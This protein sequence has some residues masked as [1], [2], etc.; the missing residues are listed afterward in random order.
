MDP[1]SVTAGVMGIL[2]VVSK[3]G[4]FVHQV[5]KDFQF[6][7]EDLNTAREHALLL[8][9]EINALKSQQR[10]S[11]QSQPLK[12]AK[13]KC[14]TEETPP[15]YLTMEEAAIQQAVSTACHLLEGIEATLPLRAEPKTWR[16]KARWALKDKKLIQEL[17]GRLQSVESTLQGIMSMEQLRLSRLIYS[18]LLQQQ[19]TIDKIERGEMP[20]QPIVQMAVIGQLDARSPLVRIQA[21]LSEIDKRLQEKAAADSSTSSNKGT[22]RSITQPSKYSPRTSRLDKWG[23]SAHIVAIPGP[24]NINYRAAVHVAFLGK[25]YAVQLRVSTPGGFQFSFNDTALHVHNIVANDSEMAIACRT[26]NFDRARILLTNNLAHGSD[27]TAAGWPMLDFAVESGSARLV[28]LLLDHGANPN[29]SY[30]DHNM[31]ALQASFLRNKLDIARILLSKGADVEHIDSDGYSVLSYL[32]I[33]DSKQ[34]N[35]TSFMRLLLANN[36]SEANASDE[37]GWTPFHRAAA[38]GTPE[39]V[40]NFLLLGSSLDQRAEWYGWTALFF[41]AS[42]DNV[43]TFLT[44]VGESGAGVYKTL[45]GD[46][47]NLLHCCVYFGAPQVMRLVLRHGGLDINQKTFPAPL[48]EDPELSY[49]ELTASNIALYIG[50]DRYRM[51]MDALVDTGKDEYLEDGAEA[52]WDAPDPDNLGRPDGGLAADADRKEGR[53][54]AAQIYG[55]EDVDDRWTLLHWASYNGSPKIKRLLLLKGVAPEHLEAI[56]LEDNPTLLPVSPF[57]GRDIPALTS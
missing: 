30:G 13:T 6:A 14:E 52:F 35:S 44:I 2:D 47:W 49:R 33:V 21:H 18:M 40:K 54:G 11:Y 24:K 17:Q 28:R 56:K 55:A 46:G 26:G 9:D 7:D 53:A 12:S 37:R 1:L 15:P 45:D 51:F 50:P 20:S 25:M 19:A 5:S 8:R 27:V 22:A 36:F 16:T 42:H 10:S 31:T 3:L 57:E 48:P 23:F 39:D 32:W 41:A 34:H 29:F 38:I 43:E 4:K